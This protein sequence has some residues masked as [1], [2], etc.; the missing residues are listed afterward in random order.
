MGSAAH[1]SQDHENCT[2]A[3]LAVITEVTVA[4]DNEDT[5]AVEVTW[6]GHNKYAVKRRSQVW[7]GTE[8]EYEPQPS[9]R[10]D[11]F[12]ARTRFGYE[13]AMNLAAGIVAKEVS[14]V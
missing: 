10:D 13:Q 8:W 4:T 12:I 6:R 1:W 5:Y 7:N 14:G 3:P 11:A 2:C 9:S